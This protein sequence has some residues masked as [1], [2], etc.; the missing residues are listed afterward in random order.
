MDSGPAKQGRAGC[1]GGLE[2]QVQ[3]AA[4]GMIDAYPRTTALMGIAAVVA[5]RSLIVVIAVTVSRPATIVGVGHM[6]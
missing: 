2:P 6:T 5:W 1:D 3:A 4:W